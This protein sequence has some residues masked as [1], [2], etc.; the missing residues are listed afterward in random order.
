M[1]VD[2]VYTFVNLDD[3]S[4][5]QKRRECA[6]AEQGVDSE[7][8]TGPARFRDSG[9]MEHSLKTAKSYLPFLRNIYVVHTGSAPD[10]LRQDNR[11]VLVGNEDVVPANLHPT[12]Q[13]DVIEAYIH[14]IPGLSERYLYSNDD[15][16]FSQPHDEADFYTPD[17]RCKVGIDPRWVTM[18][19]SGTFK[20]MEVNSVHS[21]QKR[22]RNLPAIPVAAEDR[23]FLNSTRMRMQALKRGIRIMNSVTHVTQPFLKSR[24]ADFHA[25]F[26]TEMKLLTQT[27]FRSSQGFAIN[28]MYHHYLRSLGSAEFYHDPRH[29]FIDWRDSDEKRTALLHHI[30]THSPSVTR[31]CLN[32][33]HEEDN[34]PSGGQRDWE[35]YRQRLLHAT[36]TT[37]LQ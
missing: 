22:L 23:S 16:F 33:H 6:L 13:S 24:W 1:D 21:L 4:F 34:H 2:L 14:R 11:V 3:D 28:L 17:G 32:D 27:R 20:D 26:D 31:Y 36:S 25:V 19:V 10:W 15:F 9:E 29:W 7:Y 18:G 37:A 12:F 5:A 35:T 30:E 8:R